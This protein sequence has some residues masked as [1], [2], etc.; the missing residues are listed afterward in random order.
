MRYPILTRSRGA[1]LAA[2]LAQ[3][4][5]PAIE[6][7]VTWMGTDE[8]VDLRPLREAADEF[9]SRIARSDI[10]DKDRFEGKMAP[11]LYEA[12]ADIPGEVLDD[13]GFWAYLSLSIFW[14]F[15]AWREEDAFSRGNY[16]K[17]VDGQSAT[18]SVLNRMLVRA[19]AVGGATYGELASSIPHGTDFWRSHV[20]RV[21][22][23]TAPSI[24]RALV[25]TQRDDRLPT[26]DLRDLARRLNRTWANVV[27]H[28]H[29][30]DEADEL[31]SELRAS[32]P[33]HGT[34]EAE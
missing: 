31:I 12:M 25:R 2:Q 34:I 22:T 32:L 27:L 11:R 10:T 24:T 28:T 19:S 3:G 1:D 18:E 4:A 9:M 6:P 5:D 29:D 8:D 26:D 7:H 20:I 14:D 30:D 21:R 16:L 23:G 17:Y 15:I 13:P 33:D